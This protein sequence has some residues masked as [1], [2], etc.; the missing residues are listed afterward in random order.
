MT[1]LSYLAAL[2]TTA[3]LLAGFG[4]AAQK[5]FDPFPRKKEILKLFADEFVTLTPGT[6]RFPRSFAMGSP[7][8]A[9]QQPVHDVAFARG[10]ALAKYEVTQELYQ[11]VM[12]ENPSKWKGPRNAVELTTWHDANAF[13]VKATD[14]L[15]AGKWIDVKAKIRLPSEAEWEYACR[16][17]TKSA[18]SFGDNLD[19]LTAYCWYKDN[20][21]GHDPPVG[22]KKPNPWGFYDMHGY[23]WEW[24]ADDYAAS[25]KDAP[26]D[27]KAFA[28]PAGSDKVIRGGAWNAPADASRSAHRHHAKADHKDDTLGFRCVKELVD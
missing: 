28:G 6:G 1:R 22:L 18:W 10:F 11:V 27:G 19:D 13:S 3:V 9:D 7:A 15:R 24:V 2:F 17:G 8:A 21:K 12:G 26:K 23:N 20:S 4:P 5:D 16:A 25:Y 14:L